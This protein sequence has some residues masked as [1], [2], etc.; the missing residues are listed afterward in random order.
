M[1]SVSRYWQIQV[2]KPSREKTAFITHYGLFEFCVKLFRLTNALAAFQWLMQKVLSDL[3]TD[4]GRE[5]AEVYIDDILI[6]SET[7][8]EN[9]Q[10]IHFV[11]E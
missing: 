2:D 10:H 4:N 5:F 11:L 3:K 1:D 7:L 8:E 6:F 9:L